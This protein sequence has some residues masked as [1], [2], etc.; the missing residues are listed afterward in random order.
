MK[1]AFLLLLSASLLHAG[2]LLDGVAA[3]VNG[4]TIHFERPG[5]FGAYKWQK[6]I[7]ELDDTER[8]AL[9]RSR[10]NTKAK[11]D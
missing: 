11:Q 3:R 7:S 2:E 8:A 5:P 9:E 4:D 1:P 10:T 6:K